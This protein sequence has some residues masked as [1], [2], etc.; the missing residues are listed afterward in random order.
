MTDGEH[1]ECSRD[2]TGRCNSLI[3]RFA[4]YCPFSP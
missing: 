3:K 2:S 4:I 1:R